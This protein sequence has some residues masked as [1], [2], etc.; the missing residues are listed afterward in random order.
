MWRTPES[1][2]RVRAPEGLWARSDPAVFCGYFPIGEPGV[3]GTLSKV[4][5][6][7]VRSTAL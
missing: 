2:A 6:I 3:S 5:A 7:P 1:V 4:P